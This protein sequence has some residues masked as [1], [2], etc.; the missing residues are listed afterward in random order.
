MEMCERCR[1]ICEDKRIEDLAKDIQKDKKKL[2]MML[3]LQ[4]Q[5]TRLGSFIN[6]G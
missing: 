5:L 3:A 1:S 6:Q 2:E 4:E